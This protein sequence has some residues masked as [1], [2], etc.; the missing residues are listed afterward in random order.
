VTWETHACGC[1]RLFVTAEAL[2]KHQRAAHPT[3]EAQV[4]I[5][6]GS[7]ASRTWRRWPRERQDRALESIGARLALAPLVEAGLASYDATDDSFRLREDICGRAYDESTRIGFCGV[8]RGHRG[9]HGRWL[10]GAKDAPPPFPTRL[11]D[12]LAK[13]CEERGETSLR[14]IVRRDG[15][16]ISVV[17]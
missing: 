11:W 13:L 15:E 8:A 10:W 2:A 12:H 16:I 1:G 7:R 4:S 17:A 5:R 9:R 14:I 6:L 3:P